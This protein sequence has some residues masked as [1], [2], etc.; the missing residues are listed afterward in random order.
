MTHVLNVYTV[1][2]IIP[3]EPFYTVMSVRLAK[4]RLIQT[5]VLQPD[6]CRLKTQI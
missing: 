4:M 1:F 3:E 2:R 6:P 5:I